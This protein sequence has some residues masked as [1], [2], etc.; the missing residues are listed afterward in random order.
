ML[1]RG[2]NVREKTGS[3]SK[4]LVE[5]QEQSSSKYIHM[6]GKSIDLPG[7]IRHE[8]VKKVARRKNRFIVEFMISKN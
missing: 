4:E 7:M 6:L 5:Q 2:E 1:E 8:K 3:G